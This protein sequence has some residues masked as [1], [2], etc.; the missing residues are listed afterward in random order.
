MINKQG[1]GKIDW[2]DWTWNPISGCL[3][4]CPYCYMKRMEKRFPGL[5]RPAFHP[6]RL[7]TFKRARKVKAGDKVFVGSSGDMWGYWV[8]TAWISEVLAEVACLNQFTFQFLT[9]NP[10]GYREWYLS[11]YPHCWF[12]TTVDGNSR[13]KDNIPDLINSVPENLIRFVSFEPLLCDPTP[14]LPHIGMLDWIIVGADSTREA[15]KPPNR[16]ASWLI[17][18]A[19]EY[20]VPVW[21]KDNYGYPDTI[22]EFPEVSHGR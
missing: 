17:E 11:D 20:N 2:T 3:H 19:R 6:D 22:K 7:E 13:T 8:K 1:P 18:T 4:G 10:D 14:H 5:M 21:V 15:V 9:K 16:W 12:G